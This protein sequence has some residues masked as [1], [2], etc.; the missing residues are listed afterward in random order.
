VSHHRLEPSIEFSEDD[1]KTWTEPVVIVR[2]AEVWGCYPYVFEA[3]PGEVWI[4][5][6]QS[7]LRV[8]LCERDVADGGSGVRVVRE[9]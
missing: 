8:R 9:T 1:G 7:G 5:T 6:R 2:A 3:D 4:T